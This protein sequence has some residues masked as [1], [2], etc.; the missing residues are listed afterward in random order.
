M[1]DQE[2]LESVKH[3]KWVDEIYFPAPWSY[4]IDFLKKIDCDFVAHDVAPYGAGETEDVYLP[5]KKLG[6]YVF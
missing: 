5:M 6:M 2:R 1:N 3:C 4:Q